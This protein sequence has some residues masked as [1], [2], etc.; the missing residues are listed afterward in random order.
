MTFAHIVIGVMV[1][2]VILGM[3]AGKRVPEAP[4]DVTDDAIRGL[5]KAG[6]KIQAIK[7]YRSLHG[8]GLKE[9]KEA[10]ETM[11]DEA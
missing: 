3:L 10:V 6:Q 9:A 7:W 5:A 4:S 2:F 11:V 1:A 8:V